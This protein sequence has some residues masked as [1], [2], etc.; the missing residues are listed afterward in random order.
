M[1]KLI[2]TP[3]LQL[4]YLDAEAIQPYQNNP[5]KHPRRQINHLKKS[6]TAYGLV[7]PI[8]V[9]QSAQI[10]AGH[11][12]FQAACELGI[13]QIPVI[14]V[15][16]MT[17]LQVQAYRLADNRLSELS[18]W[19]DTLLAG[20]L[21]MLGAVN[22]DFDIEATGF[23]VG[24]IDMR[25]ESLELSDASASTDKADQF[26]PASGPP[27]AQIGDVW[28]LGP[29]RLI[30]GN[31]LDAAM[32]LTLMGDQ[33]AA[34]AFTD[35]PYNVRVD[36]HVGGK[37]SIKHREFA[38]ASGEMSSDQ[39]A[40]F[41]QTVCLRLVEHST[42]GSVHMICMDWRHLPELLAAGGRAYTSML[43]ICV[44]AKSQAGMG[45]LYRSQHEMVLVYKSGKASH[46]NN[47]ELGRFGRHRSNIWKY[48]SIHAM[49]HGE[50]GDLL[51]LHPTVK[52]VKMVADAILDCSRRGDLIL[53]PFLGSG[54]TLLACERTGRICRAI[55]LDPLY[56][57]TA[58]RRWREL[59]GEDAVLIS[60]GQTFTQRQQEAAAVT[61]SKEMRDGQK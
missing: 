25:I 15:E 24:E 10:I 4:E 47:V 31:S 19:D 40:S 29:H 9:D 45:S 2:A 57:D 58:I 13:R 16:H 53:E 44:W 51:A 60:T 27:V 6:I 34:M 20:E 35:P 43:N 12:R 30:C 8:L 32:Y 11:G 52:P 3:S 39:F 61:V 36:G 56:V 21:K 37:G 22:L 48:P 46:R 42:D 17:M 55:E 23:T 38:M 28:E 14:R 5:R 1:P 26:I 49:R 18:S 50:E 7:T 59:T 41:L 54:T 33:K